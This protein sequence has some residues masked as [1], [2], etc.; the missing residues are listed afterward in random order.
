MKNFIEHASEP[1]KASNKYLGW[2][3]ISTKYGETDSMRAFFKTLS[4]D[5]KKQVL[6]YFNIK[7]D[8]KAISFSKFAKLLREQ[9][10]TKA[11]FKP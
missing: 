5:A 9:N 1:R 3:I 2:F 11:E 10:T 4:P 8:D 7:E 6:G